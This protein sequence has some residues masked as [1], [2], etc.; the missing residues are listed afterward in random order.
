MIKPRKVVE[1]M[2]AYPAP[3]E[4][5]CDYV[6]LDFNEN[7]TGFPQ[8]YPSGIPSEA[9]S[10]YPEYGKFLAKAATVF[11]VDETCMVATNGSDEALM[12]VALT[13][14]DPGDRAVLSK[15]CFVVM[16]HC[17]KLAGAQLDEVPVQNDLS[18]DLIGLEARFAGAKIAMFATPEN[19]TGAIIPPATI[20][21]WCAKFPDTLFVID[22]AYGD[23]NEA[24]V[25]PL[26]N[27]YENLLVMR[28]FSKAWG[29]AG[30]RLGLL[31]GC[32]RLIDYIRRIKL[33][34]SVNSAAAATAVKLLDKA[35]EVRNDARAT[36]ERKTKVEKQLKERGYTVISGYANSFLL[37]F[38]PERAAQF[39]SFARSQGVLVRR[40]EQQ[41]I[42]VSVGTEAEMKKFM[43]VVEKFETSLVVQK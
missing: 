30:F 2:K 25:L 38:P 10:A 29:M 31:F 20:E 34:Y 7:T 21:K 24:T 36:I 6:R 8:A 19:P 18:F 5:R 4:G 42:R 11:G 26:V 23:Y 27:K 14:V 9:V 32:P 39:E 17:L 37:A 33:P 16:P 41:Y 13:F 22:E 28:T 12:L 35:D 40:R 3:S 1:E 43:D 15:P